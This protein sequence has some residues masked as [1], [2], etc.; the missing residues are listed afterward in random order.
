[1]LRERATAEL[2]LAGRL[3]Y[4]QRLVVGVDGNLS[5]RLDDGHFLTTPAGRCKGLL[6]PDELVTLDARGAVVGGGRPSTEFGMHRA[7]YE[8]RAD[9]DAVLH[10][11]PAH[12]TAHAAAGRPLDQCILP[13]L[14]LTVG[15]V[16]V[17]DYATPS[18]DEVA[19]A[20]RPLARDHGAILLRNHGIVVFGQGVMATLHKL[21]SIELW[22][23]IVWLAAFLGGAQ[24]LT[25]AQVERLQSIRHVYGLTR[26]VPPCT[27]ADGELQAARDERLE[28]IVREEIRRQLG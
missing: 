10:A 12:C 19:A 14:V 18:T 4:E 26:L 8:E 11:H 2:I 28:R 5:A 16:P 24:P 6:S 23:Q 3:M 1:M 27:A 25:Q 7:I 22:A 9:V 15:R 13:E 17:S 21:E 20:V